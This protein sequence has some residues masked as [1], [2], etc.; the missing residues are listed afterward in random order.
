MKNLAL[1]TAV[2]TI[3]INSGLLLGHP[4]YYTYDR[5]QE[6]AALEVR[7]ANIAFPSLSGAGLVRPDLP[8]CCHNV[9]IYTHNLFTAYLFIHLIYQNTV[10][11]R[12]ILRTTAG[13]HG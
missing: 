10:C 5:P 13:R 1:P 2:N 6:K 8:R 11:V 12:E 4:V 9:I 3:L 7:S